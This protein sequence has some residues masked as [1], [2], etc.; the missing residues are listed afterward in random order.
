MNKEVILNK[1]FALQRFGIKPGLDRTLKLSEVMG[2]PNNKFKS[3][4][5]SGTNGKGS[6]CS[7]LASIFT[8]AGYK[9]GLYTSPHIKDFNER[10]RI[11]GKKISDEKLIEYTEQLLPYQKLFNNTFFEITTVLAF[12]YFADEQ[13]DL[14]IIETGMGGRYDSTN[15]IQPVLSIITKIDID[16]TQ[17]LGQ[18]INEIALEK[19]GIMKQ[20]SFTVISIENLGLKE[21]FYTYSSKDNLNFTFSTN[22]YL[23]DIRYNKDLSLT[24]SIFYKN[25]FYQNIKTYLSGNHQ[26]ENINLAISSLE[27]LTDEFNFKSNAIINGLKN[28]KKNT[29][30]YARI[31]NLSDYVNFDFPLILDVAHNPDA[32]KKTFDTLNLHLKNKKW[33][34]VFASMKDKDFTKN[35]QILQ[36]FCQKLIITKPKIDRSAKISDI[37]DIAQKL[38]FDILVQENIDEIPDVILNLKSPILVVGSFYLIGDFIN[39]LEQK[40]NITIDI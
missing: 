16:H 29:G 17:Y 25:E 2:N 38:K 31:T 27:K 30:Y 20:N 1:L 15:I 32:I 21:V 36:P 14:A 7:I 26:I 5:V 23:S 3:I 18:T 10:I 4:H 33:T 28:L 6:V 13:V 35:L 19:A 40:F 34:I 12:K 22:K 11:N 8:E 39:S 24:F 37:Y 9:V